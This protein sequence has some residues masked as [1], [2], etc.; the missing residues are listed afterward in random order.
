MGI[1]KFDIRYPSG[2]REAIVVESARAV[3]GSAAHCDVRLALDQAAYEQLVVEAIGGTLRAEVKV[4]EPKVTL[5]GMAFS[6]ATLPPD[7]M[8]EVRG[9][10]I[11][12][13]L[14][15][16]VPEGAVATEARKKEAGPAFGLVFI[17]VLAAMAYVM[18]SMDPDA[19]EPPPAGVPELFAA[20]AATCP[21]GDPSQAG[22][23]AE[24]QMDVAE[25]KRERMPF[26][27]REGL[28]AAQLYDTAAACFR[29]AANDARA[30]DAEEASKSLK[31]ALTDE[32]RTRQLRL[33]HTLKVE[34]YELSLIDLRVLGQLFTD[35]KGPYV[36]WLES[37]A[38]DLESKGLGGAE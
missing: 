1:M 38:L 8:L 23:Y 16:D 15:A 25:G 37:V 4:E 35:K 20:A 22:A 6:E 26:E 9:V 18:L 34:D 30:R 3:I 36:E 21:Q 13:N 27:I 10:R 2:R 24:E 32:F 11:F 12:A 14:E 17:G 29:K 5:N 7:A 28:A 31:G 33:T 19:I